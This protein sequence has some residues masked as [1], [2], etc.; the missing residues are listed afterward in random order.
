MTVYVT[1]TKQTDQEAGRL[2]RIFRGSFVLCDL[3][4]ST[5]ASFMS[6]IRLIDTE[7]R[8]PDQNHKN[9][10]LSKQKTFNR[11]PSENTGKKDE[12]YLKIIP[13][14]WWIKP[15]TWCCI[16]TEPQIPVNYQ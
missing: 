4:F 5:Q 3:I 2:K 13:R 9:M 11:Q 14:T 6:E 7:P 1:I 16:A 15:N 10:T 8:R 12:K